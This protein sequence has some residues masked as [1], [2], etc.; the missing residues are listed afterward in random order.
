MIWPGGVAD[1]GEEGH[2]RPVL[3]LLQEGDKG[4][5][6]AHAG[7]PGAPSAP[8]APGAPSAPGRRR[9]PALH[10]HRGAVRPPGNI[11]RQLHAAGSGVGVHAGVGARRGG[12]GGR[13]GHVGDTAAAVMTLAHRFWTPFHHGDS[14]VYAA[15]GTGVTRSKA[16]RRDSG[17]AGQRRGWRA[18]SWMRSRRRRP[19]S[20]RRQKVP[21]G[22]SRPMNTSPTGL[23]RSSGRALPRR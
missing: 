5:G 13:H 10:L 20:Q 2:G 18:S 21:S 3:E 7:R 23:P 19:K 4:C 9:H 11:K 14:P 1:R 22:V 6:G 16:R 15:G 12:D 8:G 17:A